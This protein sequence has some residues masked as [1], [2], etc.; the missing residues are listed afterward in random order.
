MIRKNSKN[1]LLLNNSW[2][3]LFTY[4][5]YSIEDK[6]VIVENSN[7]PVVLYLWESKW[8]FKSYAIDYDTCKS[9]FEL[10]KRWWCWIT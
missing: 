8:D 5:E 6:T 4:P 10:N 3:N 7:E 2:I 9:R 1:E